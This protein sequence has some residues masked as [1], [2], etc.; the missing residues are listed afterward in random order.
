MTLPADIRA[1]KAEE[2]RREKLVLNAVLDGIRDADLERCID[3]LL[4]LDMVVFG[5]RKAMR[6]IARLD[7]D[8]PRSFRE[9]MLRVWIRN[10]EHIRQETGDDLLLVKALQALLPPYD[11][12]TLRI[13]RGDSAWN[14]RCRTYGLSW[15]RDLEIAEGFA[16]GM[17]QTV[18]GGSVLLEADAAPEA[19]VC[20]VEADEDQYGEKEILVDRRRLKGVRVL[21]RYDQRPV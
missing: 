9:G 16:R 15:S 6:A 12:P 8:P 17:W 13:W 10:G 20:V 21:A 4:L 14:R 19:I 1:R 18:R 5:W 7:R 3:G 2:K 11:G